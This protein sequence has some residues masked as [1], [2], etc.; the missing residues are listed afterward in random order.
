MDA[1]R[2]V[3]ALMRRARAPT[4][5]PMESPARVRPVEPDSLSRLLSLLVTGCKEYA[6]LSAVASEV[7]AD[8][9]A[10]RNVVSL[11]LERFGYGLEDD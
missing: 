2:L 8:G 5:P 11:L 4:R 7:V 9:S 3:E 1:V 10:S 6:T